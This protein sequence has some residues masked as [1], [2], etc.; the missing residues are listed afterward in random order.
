MGLKE[1]LGERLDFLDGQ[2]L[3][4]RQAGL[5]VAIWLLLTA[6]FGLLVFAV[7]FVQ[8]GF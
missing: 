5:I 6:L 8:M 2:E 3:T 1:M 4:G 7:V